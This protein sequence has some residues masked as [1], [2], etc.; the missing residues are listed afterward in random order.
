L[1]CAPDRI[2]IERIAGYLIQ[3]CLM[4]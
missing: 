3:G 2:A 4:V 1:E